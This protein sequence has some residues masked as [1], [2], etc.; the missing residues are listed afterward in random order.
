VDRLGAFGNFADKSLLAENPDF[1]WADPRSDD[2]TGEALALVGSYLPNAWGL[3]DMHGNVAEIV[4]DNHL[5]DLPGG[6]DPVA[7]A[8]KNGRPVMRGGA[9]LSTPAYCE[10]SF[11]N[12]PPSRHKS[13]YIGFRIALKKLP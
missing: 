1:H 6:T 3:R 5:S 10:S 8:E 2:G 12:S 13:N 9:W 11:R 7:K 4:A